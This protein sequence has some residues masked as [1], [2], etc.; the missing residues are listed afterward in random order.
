MNV[1]ETRH[2]SGCGQDK[3]LQQFQVNKEYQDGTTWVKTRKWCHAC[4]NA[5]FEKQRKSDLAFGK[6]LQQKHERH[7]ERLRA[8]GPLPPWCEAEILDFLVNGKTYDLASMTIKV[9]GHTRYAD[10]ATHMLLLW[11]EF[12][13]HERASDEPLGGRGNRFIQAMAGLLKEDEARFRQ[14]FRRMCKHE[15]NLFGVFEAASVVILP[16]SRSKPR[17]V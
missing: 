14:K 12:Q 1:T 3:P 6:M 4:C 17:P 15:D 7:E 5:L 9:G 8:L 13:K 11:E 2:C 10:R 16:R